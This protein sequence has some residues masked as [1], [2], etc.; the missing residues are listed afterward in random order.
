MELI[1]DILPIAML[2]M[3]P[4]Y[5]WWINKDRRRANT[6]QREAESASDYRQAALEHFRR[7]VEHMDRVEKSL[8]KIAAALEQR[9][10][11]PK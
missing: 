5:L 4:A 6:Y 8:D 7:N 10:E 2:V 11:P 1:R 9:N 3:I